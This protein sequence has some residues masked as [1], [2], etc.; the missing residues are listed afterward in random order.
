ILVVPNLEA[1]NILFKSR[2]L[3][4]GA[5]LGGVVVGARVPIIL[6]SRSAEAEERKTSAAIALVASRSTVVPPKP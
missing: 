2:A 1:G 6:N 3:M 4:S 5:A